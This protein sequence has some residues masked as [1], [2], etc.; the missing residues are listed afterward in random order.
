MRKTTAAS[1]ALALAVLAL[2]GCTAAPGPDGGDCAARNGSASI[3]SAVKVTGDLG[4]PE[5][6][7]D[8][9]VRSSR[10]AYADVIVGD[11]PAIESGGQNAIITRV[12]YNGATGQPVDG[13]TS[14]W[15]PDSTSAQFPGVGDVLE[16]ATAGSRVVAAVPAKELP[17]GMA[18]Q[19]GLGARDSLIAVFDVRYILLP[20]A[21]GRDVFN[22]ARGLPTV[23]RAADGRPGII[24]PDGAAPKKPFVQTL[25]EGEGDEVGDGA[26]MFNYTA[27][28]WADRSVAATTWDAGVSFD[29]SALPEQVT[30]AMKKAAI[31]SQLLVVVPGE[32]SDATAFVVDIL[33]VIPEELTQG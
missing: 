11:G 33:G 10:I 8:S 30:D 15:S 31:G 23:V 3:E 16:C 4:E 13:G 14:V 17:E 5:L 19:I 20:K 27:V 18:G 24:I 26:P 25:I 32:G 2:T 21:Q 22:D 6:A 7:V 28:D 9:P 12:L 1:S 29:P